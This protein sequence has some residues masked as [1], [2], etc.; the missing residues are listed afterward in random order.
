[1]PR[2]KNA[3]HER[4]CQ[5]YSKLLNATNAYKAVY[6]N[7]KGA[8][9]SA[10][11]LL[12]KDKVKERIAELCKRKEDKVETKA[13]DIVKELEAIAKARM[14][15]VFQINGGTLTIKSIEDIPEECHVAIESIEV[16]SAGDDGTVTKVKFHSKIQALKLLGKH[17]GIFNDSIKVDIPQSIEELIK[18]HKG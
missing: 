15:D 10:S 5:E 9:N 12:G 16:L 7:S 13:F 11:K 3:K 1:M 18:S 2:L 8:E 6:G 17:F 14:I 4:F